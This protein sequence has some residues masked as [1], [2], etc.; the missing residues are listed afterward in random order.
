MPKARSQDP[1]LAATT[2]YLIPVLKPLGFQRLG[3]RKFV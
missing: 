3:T 1:L 2:S